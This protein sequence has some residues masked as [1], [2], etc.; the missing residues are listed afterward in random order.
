MD[1]PYQPPSSS[2]EK[3]TVRKEGKGTLLLG[4]FLLAAASILLLRSLFPPALKD[5]VPSVP[6]GPEEWLPLATSAA[7]GLFLIWSVLRQK[8]A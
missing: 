2:N 4:I 1:N 6:D 3:T 8:R 5:G 7:V